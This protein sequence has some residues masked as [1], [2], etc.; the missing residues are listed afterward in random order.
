MSRA[1]PATTPASYTE[2]TLEKNRS[3]SPRDRSETM[4]SCQAE[5]KMLASISRMVATLALTAYSPE[6]AGPRRWERKYRSDTWMSQSHTV[7]GMRGRQ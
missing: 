7:A 3:C 2:K 5:V 1:P 4:D 6:T